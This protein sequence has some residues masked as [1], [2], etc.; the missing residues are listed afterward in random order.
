MRRILIGA[1]TSLAVWLGSTM[2]AEAQGGGI[3]PIGQTA[4]LP[5]APSS[6]YSANLYLPNPSAY[7][8]QIYVFT[9]PDKDLGPWTQIGTCNV[10]KPNPGVQNSVLNQTV[11]HNTGPSSGD[12]VKWSAQIKV[13][14]A[15]WTPL[16]DWKVQ[17]LGTRPSSKISAV[18]KSSKLAVLTTDRD[19]RRED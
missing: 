16:V 3:T 17:C 14:T 5:G 15:D 7:R 11:L 4:I 13:G 1:A 9:G 12:W 8:L 18:Q 10:I 2:V 19:R 6:T